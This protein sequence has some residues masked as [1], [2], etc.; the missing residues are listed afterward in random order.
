[1]TLRRTF[2]FIAV[3]IL[4]ASTACGGGGQVSGLDNSQAPSSGMPTVPFTPPN[5]MHPAVDPIAL[6]S[7]D[8]VTELPAEGIMLFAQD[9]F[10]RVVRGLPL[11]LSAART[12]NGLEVTVCAAR[13]AEL[14]RDLLLY[15][16]FDPQRFN[17]R[18][19]RL[20]RE[21]FPPRTHLHLALTGQRGF[22]PL[23]ASALP[24]AAAVRV[25]AADEIAR[26]SF[27]LEPQ[28]ARRSTS[29]APT[30]EGNTIEITAQV[31][32]DN[33]RCLFTERNIGDYN[34]DGS[35][36]V[37][38]LTAI[39]QH[40]QHRNAD[41]QDAII[42]GDNNGVGIS[43]ITPIAMHFGTVL[44]GYDLELEFTPEGGSAGE[45]ER[46]PNETDVNKPTMTRPNVTLPSGWPSYTFVADN[47]GY[48]TYRFRAYP[49]GATLAERGDVS[50]TSSAVYENLPPAP[51]SSLFVTA[52]TRTTVTLG[53]NPSPATDLQGYNIYMTDNP[54]A[55]SLADYA[56]VNA[57]LL[58]P[59]T[60]AL[61]VTDLTPTTDYWFVAESVDNKGLPSF[62][63]QVL[64]TKVHALTIVTPVAVLNVAAGEHYELYTITFDGIGSNSPDGAAI[65]SYTY[66]WGD[67]TPQEVFPTSDPVTHTY[68]FPY[69]TGVNVTLTVEDEYGVQGSTQQSVIVNALRKDVLV[70]YNTNSADDLEIANYYADPWTGR[71]IH[72]DFVLGMNLSMNEEIDRPTYDT[73]IRQPLINFIDTEGIKYQIYYIVVTKDV[74]IKINGT[75]GYNGSFAC[76]DSEMC[77]LYEGD[78]DLE[79]EMDNPYYGWF[80][81]A[82]GNKGNPATSQAFAPF[83]FIRDGITM[84]YLVTRLSSW[85]KEAVF[86]M[87]DRSKQADT[88]D[89]TNYVVVLDDDNKNYDMMS[90]PP[91]NADGSA[92]AVNVMQNKGLTF[93]SD[94][95]HIT[96]ADE[97]IDV[98][99]SVMVANGGNPNVVIG[100]CSHGIH[101]G[102]SSTY[103][104]NFLG[105]TPPTGYMLPGALFMSYESF[106]GTIFRGDPYTHGSHGQ[107]ADWI[108]MGGTGAIGNV[109]EPY[110]NAC[111][112]ESIIFAEYIN[113]NRNLAEALYKGLR[114]VSW[115][116]TVLG[117]P[118]CK[119]NF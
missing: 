41:V 29:A 50:N 71:G 14:P 69:A 13:D 75:G 2:A 92:S 1:M 45:F 65:V 43:D 95:V 4:S 15:L 91:Q 48:G 28:P 84:N 64:D 76:V 110:S 104:I 6:M 87:I 52:T 53:W 30:G 115:V 78:Y 107:V 80:S 20:S 35:V 74:P 99:S 63:N 111:G 67:G 85:T 49:I 59:A 81:S 21:L 12:A 68:Q 73:T 32:G 112:D 38:D 109:Y 83:T 93:F 31:L 94:R 60:L 23:A 61:E 33:I 114:R 98:S 9:E 82:P 88:A 22:V 3:L 17:P 44:T 90:E 46:I 56:K 117:D 106:N 102:M 79:L 54:A 5:Y 105:F 19:A 8:A 10:N 77:L 7:G 18:E 119:P 57:V 55:T 34:L 37:A 89:Y 24:S 101:A 86:G 103:I 36:G 27:T 70:V 51:P 58:P 62:E 39:A 47:Q 26:V 16:R 97:S 108:L 100:Y 42:D 66:D 118:L 11:T 96:P 113:C 40:W 25:R 72:P 116:E